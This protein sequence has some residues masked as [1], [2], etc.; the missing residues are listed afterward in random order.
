MDGGWGFGGNSGGGRT[1]INRI[2][3]IHPLGSS[4]D[5]DAPI[6]SLHCL[7]CRITRPRPLLVALSLS[8]GLKNVRSLFSSR[9]S[10]SFGRSRYCFPLFEKKKCVKIFSCDLSFYMISNASRFVQQKLYEE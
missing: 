7:A 4:R 6:S 2:V 10:F 3:S 8:R 5:L 1:G 9:L